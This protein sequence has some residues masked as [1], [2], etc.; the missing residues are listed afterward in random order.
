VARDATW[1]PAADGRLRADLDADGVPEE[2]HR[3]A[4]DEG[5]H[6]TVWSVH[7]DGRRERRWH[8]YFDWGAFTD[9]TCAPGDDGLG[10]AVISE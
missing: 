7:P 2:A 10:P 5:E 4:A 3:C 6:F 8:E 1:T 9:P